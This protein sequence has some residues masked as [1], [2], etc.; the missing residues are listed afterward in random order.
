[1]LYDLYQRPSNPIYRNI[2]VKTGKT[3]FIEICDIHILKSIDSYGHL[4]EL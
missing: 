2:L 3:E 1:M 4:F